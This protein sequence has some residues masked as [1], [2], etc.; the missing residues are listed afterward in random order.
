MIRVRVSIVEKRV[1]TNTPSLPWCTM[2]LKQRLLTRH[3]DI[4]SKGTYGEIVTFGSCRNIRF[5]R[6]PFACAQD[7]VDPMIT[8][9]S[10]QLLA[11]EHAG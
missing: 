8:K 1:N 5:I 7:L 4:A 11:G 6:L 3:Q 10:V 9:A 2:C